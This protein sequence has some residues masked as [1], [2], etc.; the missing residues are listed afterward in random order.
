MGRDEENPLQ[1]KGHVVAR[2][3]RTEFVEDYVSGSRKRPGLGSRPIDSITRQDIIRVLDDAVARGAPYRAHNLLSDV[4]AFFNWVVERGTYGIEASPCDRIRPKVVIGKKAIRTRVLS[5]RELRAYW[6]ASGKLGYPYGP[7]FRL[8]AITGQ[9]RSEVTVSRWRE[10][11]LDKR[12]WSI[13]AERMKA[14]APHIVPLS[15]DA[16]GVLETLPRFTGTGSGDYLFS[17]SRGQTPVNSFSKAK[18][19]LNSFMLCTLRAW[20]RIHGEDTSVIQL[21]H[22]VTHDVRRTVRT[23]LSSLPVSTDVAELVIAHTRP[24]LRKVYDQHAFEAEK[25]EALELWATCLREIVTIEFGN[26]VE[27]KRM[28]TR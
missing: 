1:R 10:F 12:I 13:P 14:D 20:A 27:L 15:E 18:N 16:L 4:R 2:N 7:L 25:R 24:G 8:L 28:A 17:A 26:V 23:R 22:F 19:R 6:R 21:P 3:L 9:R 5:D 11:D